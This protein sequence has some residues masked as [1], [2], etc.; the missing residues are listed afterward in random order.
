MR[1]ASTSW[2]G[3]SRSRNEDCGS[4]AGRRIGVLSTEAFPDGGVLLLA[5]GLGGY[6]GGDLASELAVSYLEAR[7]REAGGAP[8]WGEL[9]RG[10]N[11]EIYGR[12]GRN[13]HLCKMGATLVGAHVMMDALT[14]FHVGDSRAYL[15]RDGD[16][17]PLTADHAE[18]GVVNRALSGSASYSDI[19]PDIRALAWSRGDRLLLCTDGLTCV[20]ADDEI[21][22]ALRELSDERAAVDRLIGIT[23][24]KGA[25]DNVT[26]ALCRN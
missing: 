17:M 21:A 24:E 12:A 19:T 16:L 15:I 5:D 4:L 20:V 18:G 2:A 26:I 10:A 6:P 11:R 3:L 9:I 22:H 14:V 1:V 23:A 8:P 13:P 25:P 7:I